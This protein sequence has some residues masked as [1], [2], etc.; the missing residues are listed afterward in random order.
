[1]LLKEENEKQQKKLQEKWERE[2]NARIELM[3]DVYKNREEALWHKK[4]LED[5]ENAVKDQEKKDVRLRVSEYAEEEKR[6]ELEEIMRNKQHQNEVLWQINEKNEQKR[7]AILDEMEEERKKRLVELN[8]ER[9]IKEE[10]QI[11]RQRIA[12]AKYGRYY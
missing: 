5:A 1:M 9:R 10:E 6:K 12:E 3:K 11:G 8:Y 2:E 7:R 4:A